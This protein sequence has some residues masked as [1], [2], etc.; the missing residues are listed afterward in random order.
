MR[1]PKTSG[2]VGSAVVEFIVFVLFGQLLGFSIGMQVSQWMDTKL[3]LELAAQQQV[4]ALALGKG[5]QLLAELR[6]DLPEMAAAS[7][8]CSAELVCVT[9][10]SGDLVA[11]GV[12]LRGEN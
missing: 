5:D 11:R 12:S 8:N 3:K 2:S 4:R 7:L 10:K 9:L 6:Q 1:W